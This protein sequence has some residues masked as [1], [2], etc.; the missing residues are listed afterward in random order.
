MSHNA[1]TY[2][3]SY[4]SRGRLN[5]WTRRKT[6]KTRERLKRST[7]HMIIHAWIVRQAD[8]LFKHRLHSNLLH[9]IEDR[10]CTSCP[11][12]SYCAQIV[13]TISS[14]LISFL[15]PYC[16]RPLSRA[17]DELGPNIIV[18]ILASNLVLIGDYFTAFLTLILRWS[19][20]LCTLT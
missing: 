8:I 11:C 19:S 4:F 20:L 16:K 14:F 13:K 10:Q 15:G 18:F 6:F 5:Q 9:F 3:S 17:V 1:Q 2:F 7:M 12:C